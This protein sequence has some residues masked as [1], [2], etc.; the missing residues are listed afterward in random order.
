MKYLKIS[1]LIIG[2]CS[3][4]AFAQDERADVAIEAQIQMEEKLEE[5]YQKVEDIKARFEEK[6]RAAI[7]S[8]NSDD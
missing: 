8:A 1:L 4:N 2:I 7:E 5:S 3:A 6:K